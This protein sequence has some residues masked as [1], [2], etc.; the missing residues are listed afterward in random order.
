MKGSPEFQQDGDSQN[1][2]DSLQRKGREEKKK[3]GQ[4]MW[5]KERRRKRDRKECQKV[6]YFSLR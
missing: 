3:K 2:N 1:W 4:K 6:S 5:N